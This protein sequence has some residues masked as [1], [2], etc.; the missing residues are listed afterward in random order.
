LLLFQY[1]CNQIKKCESVGISRLGKG[2]SYAEVEEVYVRN[3][4]LTRSTSGT[5]IKTFL[6]SNLCIYGRQ[7]RKFKREMLLLKVDC[8]WGEGERLWS[9]GGGC[10]R[11]WKNLLGNVELCLIIFFA[12][13]RI[14]HVEMTFG[15]DQRLLCPGC[16]SFFHN[17]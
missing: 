11:E 4:S 3:C 12:G 16:L 15:S 9:E 8:G 7:S 17:G 13:Q 1:L 14:R 10:F 5:R 6:V 2:N